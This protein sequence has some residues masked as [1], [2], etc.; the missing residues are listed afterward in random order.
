MIGDDNDIMGSKVYLDKTKPSYV[1]PWED[2]YNL[3]YSTLYC[4]YKIV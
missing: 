1:N 4:I 2:P 3:I